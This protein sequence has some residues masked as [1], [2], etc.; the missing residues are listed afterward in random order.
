MNFAGMLERHRRSLLFLAA[1]LTVGGIFSAFRLPVALFPN[2]QFPRIVIEL[3]AGDRPA[4]QTELLVT[5]PVELAVR[6]IPGVESVRSTTSRGSAEIYVNFGW[7]RD[8]IQAL[9]SVE[10]GVNVLL[11]QLPAGT[12][13]TVE[14]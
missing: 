4:S 10:S 6:A 12:S 8:M 7:G 13:F 14:R 1:T 11:P 5:R 2:T 9:L 3:D